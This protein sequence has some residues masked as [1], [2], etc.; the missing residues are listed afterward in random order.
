MDNFNIRMQP[1][2]TTAGRVDLDVVNQGPS[3]HQLTV[4]RTD[5]PANKLPLDGVNVD[6]SAPGL[7]SVASTRN[8]NPGDEVEETVNLRPGRYV[9]VCNIAG[10]YLEGMFKTVRVSGR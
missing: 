1:P 3:V 4:I 5:L 9:F 8:L 10:H 2:T 7:D 6:L